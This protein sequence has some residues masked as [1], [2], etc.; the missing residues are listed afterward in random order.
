MQRAIEDHVAQADSLAW[1]FFSRLPGGD[2]DEL[3]SIAREA[4]VRAASRWIDPYCSSRG[5]DPWDPDDPSRPERHFP[6]YCIKVIKGALMDWARHEDHLTRSSRHHVKALQQ[7]EDDGIRGEANLASAAGITV[8]KAREVRAAD[9]RPVSLDNPA[10]G[11]E[12]DGDYGAIADS[13]PDV[14]AQAG[15]NDVLAAFMTCFDA[16]PAIQRVLL[17][18]T[19]H[20]EM[21]LEVAAKS[22]YLEPDEARRQLEAAV[23]EVHR[24]LLLS[25]QTESPIRQVTVNTGG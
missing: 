20:Q 16:L 23:L 22:V 14:E 7:A 12:Y 4:L 15:M 6:G 21:T 17:S 19:Y 9:V 18:L 11:S 25:V 8:Q 1:N 3:K 2:L 24:V 10:P 5:F 13:G